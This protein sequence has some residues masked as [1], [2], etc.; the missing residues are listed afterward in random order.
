MRAVVSVSPPA[1]AELKGLEFG[2]TALDAKAKALI[3]IAVAAQI[4]C[5]YCVWSDT[6]TAKAAGAS[7]EEVAEAVAISALTRH[8]STFF[9]GMQVDFDQFK[10]ELGGEMAAQ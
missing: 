5:H 2:E 9:H 10:M 1:W 7:D 3:G 6:N 8:W 4:P